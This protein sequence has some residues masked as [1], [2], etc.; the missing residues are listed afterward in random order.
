[1]R[2]LLG[3]EVPNDRDGCMQDIHWMDGAF[4]YFPT[5][6]LGAMA[7]SQ[8]FQAAEAA[9][10]DLADDLARGDFSRLMTWLGEKVHS[11]GRLHGSA[12]ALLTAATGAPLDGAIF[13]R[14][15]EKRYLGD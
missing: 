6:T 12:D 2:G 13:R 11:Q 10:P 3:V 15:L 9:L 8:L 7:A 14:H 4:G 1:M 5:Y